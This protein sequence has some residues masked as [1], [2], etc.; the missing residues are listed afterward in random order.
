[1]LKLIDLLLR[2]LGNNVLLMSFRMVSITVHYMPQ[3]ESNEMNSLHVCLSWITST[4]SHP[5]SMT[6]G[7][8][9]ISH[10]KTHWSRPFLDLDI[11]KYPYISANGHFWSIS[12]LKVDSHCG[13]FCFIA[14][15]LNT[16]GWYLH[17]QLMPEL[18]LT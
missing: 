6:H 16:Q 13:R 10:V 2:S 14:S 1:M 18:L 11:L 17:T 4:L 15:D 7:S 12:V 5:I 9:W 3:S 8:K